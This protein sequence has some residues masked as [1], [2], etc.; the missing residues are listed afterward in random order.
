MKTVEQYQVEYLA[1]KSES[2]ITK[3]HKLADISIEMMKESI[4]ALKA[5]SV[6]VK[7][8]CL[9]LNSF[10]AVWRSFAT[11]DK[12]ISPSGFDHAFKVTYPQIYQKW[13]LYRD[14]VKNAVSNESKT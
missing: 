6:S 1:L 13:E 4:S 14:A 12:T 5:D 3:A 9:I 11:C 7:D 2:R 10:D 8:A